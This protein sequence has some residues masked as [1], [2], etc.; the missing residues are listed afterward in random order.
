MLSLIVFTS[1]PLPLPLLPALG[2]EV[3]T[4]CLH[5]DSNEPTEN[6]QGLYLTILPLTCG[7][8]WCLLWCWW[9]LHVSWSQRAAARII[10]QH[11]LAGLVIPTGMSHSLLYTSHQYNIKGKS[12][13]VSK[14][15]Q[16]MSTWQSVMEESKKCERSGDC[17]ENFTHWCVYI[18]YILFKDVP[19][20]FILLDF[21]WNKLDWEG[22]E[23]TGKI[24]SYFA[25]CNIVNVFVLG[26]NKLCE[27][28]HKM[29]ISTWLK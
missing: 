27:L 12:R 29:L 8:S 1:S 9:Y 17:S 16:Q 28:S 25:I 4:V 10:P 7:P 6:F 3:I 5:T 23:N 22:I 26:V 24:H 21:I 18:S 15:T 2:P 13:S 11:V 19:N 14:N 20:V